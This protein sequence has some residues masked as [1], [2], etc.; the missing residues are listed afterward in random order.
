MRDKILKNAL[1]AGS[2]DS[3]GEITIKCSP[4]FFRILKNYQEEFT[5]K[6]KV[7]PSI[8]EITDIIAAKI[9]KIGG[10]KV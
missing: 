9:E 4:A 1:N 10:L 6:Y 3:S 2:N 8:E 7:K 5:E